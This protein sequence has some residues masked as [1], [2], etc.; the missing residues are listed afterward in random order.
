MLKKLMLM[1]KISYYLEIKHLIETENNIKIEE[2]EASKD[3][4]ST[5]YHCL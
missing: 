2:L 4:I 3:F 1:K 5:L